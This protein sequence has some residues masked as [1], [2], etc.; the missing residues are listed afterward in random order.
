MSFLSEHI[1]LDHR[2]PPPPRYDSLQPT[3]EQYM[4]HYSQSENS[5]LFI[6]ANERTVY[7]AITANERT[8]YDVITVNQ[9][10]VCGVITANQRTVNYV[11]TAN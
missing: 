9:R 2:Q 7:C 11:I 10:T 3:R 6:T 8:V 1:Q 4:I 5:I